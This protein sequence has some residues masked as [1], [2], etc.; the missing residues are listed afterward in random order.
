VRVLPLVL[1]LA[2]F[3]AAAQDYER[4]K[5]WAAEVVPNLVIGDAV[6]VKLPSGRAFLGLYTEAKN[7]RTAILL[8][9]G[10]GVH[11][12]H[13]IIGVLRVVLSEMGY[14]TLSIQMPVQ[15]SDA[16]PDE[17]PVV[18][19]EAAA[20]IQAGADWLAAKG[21]AQPVLLSHSMGSR[22]SNVYFERTRDAP[23]AAWV[24]MGLSGEF[25][26]MGN[27]RVP[28]LDLYGEN[29]LSGVLRAD[30]RRRITLNTI[31]GSKQG[32]IAGADH[33][34]T[35]REKELAAAIGAFLAALNSGT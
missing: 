18:F 3:S 33:F 20:R 5:R 16:A 21:F 19:P 6:Q 1:L 17:Y 27:V 30:W 4:E 14:S 31:P 34:Y 7:P 32:V 2:A 22:M 10:V 25:G 35:G 26:R 12:D 23:F 13:S 24:C 11:P 8:V 28:V 9:H 15:R 29:D